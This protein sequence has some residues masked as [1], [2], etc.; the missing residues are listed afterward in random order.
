MVSH[1]IIALDRQT[2]AKVTFKMAHQIKNSNKFIDIPK[3]QLKFRVPVDNN[4]YPFIPRISVKPNA[5]IPLDTSP[6]ENKKGRIIEWARHPYEIEIDALGYGE[7][8]DSSKIVP[9]EPLPLDET[10]LTFIDKLDDLHKLVDNLQK[11][12]E[13]AVDLEEN[14]IRSYLVCNN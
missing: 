11:C 4:D 1:I 7:D 12:T 6:I 9:I 13:I 2:V 5:I 14:C 10:P 3:P 8:F